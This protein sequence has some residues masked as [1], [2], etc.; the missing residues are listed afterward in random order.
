L[1][2]VVDL[3]QKCELR[4]QFILSSSCCLTFC[5]VLSSND[6]TLFLLQ[7]MQDN[8][9]KEQVY[10]HSYPSFLTSSNAL[11][12]D[13]ELK[14][15]GL[16]DTASR[17]LSTSGEDWVKFGNNTNI[18]VGDSADVAFGRSTVLSA[19]GLTLAVSAP[20]YDI[21]GVLNAGLVKVYRKA[22]NYWSQIGEEFKGKR[23]EDYFGGYVSLS[24]D[25]N[26]VAIG[27]SGNDDSGT[28]AGQVRV[29][30][31][32]STSWV[33]L[34]QDING[35][36]AYD[37]LGGN[38]LSLSGN[39]ETVAVGVPHINRGQVRIYSL[40]IS[41]SSTWVKQGDNINSKALRDLFG[42][43]VSLSVD[44]KTVAI[45]ATDSNSNGSKSGQVEVYRHNSG[46]WEQLG[47]AMDGDAENDYFGRSVSLSGNGETVAVGARMLTTMSDAGQVK[48]Y[49][50]QST[51]WEQVGSNIDGET[52]NEYSSVSVSLSEDGHTVAI[53]SQ[54]YD[55]NKGRVRVYGFN[56]T[57]WV[58]L[59]D[60][61][62]GEASGDQFGYSVS[63]SHDGSVVAIGAPGYDDDAGT[64]NSGRV[65][66]YTRVST[67]YS[68]LQFTL[69]ILTV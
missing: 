49:T 47:S 45:G 21:N 9:D 63:L 37:Y 28:Q 34:G 12:E 40:V 14:D 23:A 46:A 7:N 57:S 58:Q 13:E 67:A 51:E 64:N 18:T 16:V 25:G 69:C 62:D 66:V 35:E 48:V 17:A 65:R 15:Y 61:I 29:F 26:T 39:G 5:F 4:P 68:L 10:F 41:S 33:Q 1:L 27:A 42:I 43:S 8:N 55:N 60:D 54:G 38:S 32:I 24:D 19:D 44:G 52:V 11:A 56:E 20:S 53:G 50:Y 36:A 31:Y 3:F 30:R 22:G 6:A 2:F 59:G